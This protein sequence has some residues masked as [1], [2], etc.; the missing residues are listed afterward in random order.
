MTMSEVYV[1]EDGQRFKTLDDA[2]EHSLSLARSFRRSLVYQL[3]DQ[4]PDNEKVSLI[5]DLIRKTFEWELTKQ[6]GAYWLH[7][8]G[9]LRDISYAMRNE[10]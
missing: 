7:V 2:K 10:E 3:I 4:L 9:E 1:T 5:A 8:V 6:G